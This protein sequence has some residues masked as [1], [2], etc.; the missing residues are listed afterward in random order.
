MVLYDSDE[1]EL[2]WGDIK[3]KGLIILKCSL[4][5]C[6]M[7]ARKLVLKKTWYSVGDEVQW[8]VAT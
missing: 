1:Q 2:E 7:Q 3:V 8:T 5:L 6:K 4:H